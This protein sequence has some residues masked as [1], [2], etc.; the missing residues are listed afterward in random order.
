VHIVLL[1]IFMALGASVAFVAGPAAPDAMHRPPRRA[2]TQFLDRHILLAIATTAAT[3]TLAVLPAY[4]VLTRFGASTEQARTGAVLAWLAAHA[5][6]A[7]TL[8]TQP[9][10]SWKTNPAFPVWATAA[11]GTGPAAALTPAGRLIHL[12]TLP[13]QLAHH[14][15]SSALILRPIRRPAF[16]PPGSGCRSDEVDRVP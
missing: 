7:W 1:E 3:L 13:S 5:L 11:V 9:T 12:D 15:R 4:L 14:S 8:R 10:L 16:R 6:I 2:G